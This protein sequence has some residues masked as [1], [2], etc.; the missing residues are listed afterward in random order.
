MTRKPGPRGDKQLRVDDAFDPARSVN[1]SNAAL[2]NSNRVKADPVITEGTKFTK[3]PDNWSKAPAKPT[4]GF[5]SLPP[6]VY[7][8]PP[9]SCAARALE[10]T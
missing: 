3:C 8:L 10:A 2:R 4:G 5:S 1:A 7:A 6:G 9:S